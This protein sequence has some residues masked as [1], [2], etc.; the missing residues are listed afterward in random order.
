MEVFGFKISEIIEGTEGSF[1]N[2]NGITIKINKY[3]EEI[4][5]ELKLISNNINSISNFN[6]VAT[7][8]QICINEDTIEQELLKYILE[9]DTRTLLVSSNEL[10][11]LFIK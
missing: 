5:E 7:C 4:D 8:N 6:A 9:D 11:K 1:M 10:E 3:L 2:V